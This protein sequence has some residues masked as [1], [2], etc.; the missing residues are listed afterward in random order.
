MRH[1]VAG[2][3]LLGTASLAAAEDVEILF[4]RYGRSAPIHV[5]F[6]TASELARLESGSTPRSGR[7]PYSPSRLLEN[8]RKA[9]GSYQRE[10]CTNAP[11]LEWDLLSPIPDDPIEY[12]FREHRLAFVGRIVRIAPGWN[13]VP[14]P[15][16]S[17]ATLVTVEVT[18][19]LRDDVHALAVGKRTSFVRRGGEFAF[20]DTVF[21]TRNPYITP[22]FLAQDVVVAGT[23][24]ELD[25]PDALDA[26][27]MSFEGGVATALEKH[28][29]GPHRSYQPKTLEDLKRAA[30]A[31]KAT[32]KSK[33]SARP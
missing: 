8:A 3:I 26:F 20:E 28:P 16:G 1:R 23:P 24:A 10:G 18:E 27:V 7:H 30:L 25:G 14:P 12:A 11:T 29:A 6:I 17:V 9:K 13:P 2:V 4:G 32:A 21:C 15:G 22:V 33:A 19:I 5:R 31:G